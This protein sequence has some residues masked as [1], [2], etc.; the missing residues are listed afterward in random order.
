V[1]RLAPECVR[2]ILGG[3]VI[4][5]MLNVLLCGAQSCQWAEPAS[6]A[7]GV[8]PPSAEDADVDKGS[9]C[10]TRHHLLIRGTLVSDNHCRVAMYKSV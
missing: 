9:V 8:L 2:C 10:S 1:C 5:D 7:A 4:H 6:R 3:L